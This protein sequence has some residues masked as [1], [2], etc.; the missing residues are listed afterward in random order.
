MGHRSTWL[1]GIVFAACASS[2]PGTQPHDMSQAAHEQQAAAHA[3]QAE[4]HA[5]QYDPAARVA[6]ERCRTAVRGELTTQPGLVCWSSVENPTDVHRRQAEEHRRMAEAHRAASASLR[7]AEARAC[8]GISPA[9][10]DESPFEHVEDIAS[11]APYQEDAGTPKSPRLRTAG[12]VVTFRAVPGMTAEWL[13]RV[14]DCHLARNA[15]LGH[16]VPEMPACPL[17]PKGVSAKVKS[18]GNGFAV[19]VRSDDD[20]TAREILARAERLAAPR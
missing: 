14:V 16:Q 7:A 20:A 13:Q 9:D 15:A 10:R 18:T 12:A 3:R 17:V 2:T 1:V 8:V 11:V 6:G 4:E 19:I 5:A